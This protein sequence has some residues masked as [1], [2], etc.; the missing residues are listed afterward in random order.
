[1]LRNKKNPKIDE[2]ELNKAARAA[3]RAQTRTERSPSR[4]IS[5]LGTGLASED[6][7][8][9]VSYNG[10]KAQLKADRRPKE[11]KKSIQDANPILKQYKLF[12]NDSKKRTLLIQYPNREVGAEYRGANGQKPLELRM[13]PKTGVVEIDIPMEIHVNYDKEKG[14]EYGEAMRDSRV[15]QQ[16]GSYGL[17]GGLCV[18]SKSSANDARRAPMPEGPSKE[19][20]LDNFEDANNKGHVMNKITLGGRVVPFQDGDPIYMYATFKGGEQHR[21]NSY[22]ESLLANRSTDICSFTKID[23]M[24]QLRPQFDHVDALRDREKSNPRADHG[25]EETAADEPEEREA[26][27]VNMAVKSA[28]NLEELDLYGGMSTTNKL[29][30]HIRDEPWQRLQWIDQDVCDLRLFTRYKLLTFWTGARVVPGLRRKFRLP[31]PGQCSSA[32]L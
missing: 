2:T 7:L 17:S 26:R 29:L 32:R 8:P 6:P 1:M 30:K 18:G 4:G 10:I 12:I 19:K 24:V 11:L 3:F 14:I 31:R 22:N 27:A 13:K 21:L 9:Y 23:A 15:L 16:G 20:L 28:E 5:P 25:A